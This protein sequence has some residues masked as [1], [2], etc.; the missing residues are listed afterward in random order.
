[1]GC[2]AFRSKCIDCKSMVNENVDRLVNLIKT[3][4]E[5][6]LARWREQVRQLPGAAGL[7]TPTINDEVPQLLDNL[8]EVLGTGSGTRESNAISAEHGLLRWQAGFD[9]TEVVAEYN[10][11]RQCLQDAAERD[12]IVLAGKTLQVMNE[13]FDDA[14]GKAVKAFETMMTIQLQHRHDEHLAFLLHDLRTPLEALSLATTLLE[15]SLPVDNRDSGIDSALSVLRGNINRLSKRVRLVISTASIIGRSF[16]PE[17]TL[18]NLQAQVEKVTRDLQPL[19]VSTGTALRNQVDD[20][21]EVYSDEILLG[22][23]FENLLSNALKFTSH[24]VIEIGARETSDGHSIQ[25]W[26]KDSGQGIPSEQIERIFERFETGS[27]PEQSGLGLGLAIVKEIIELHR[28]EI[29]VQS[30]LG[31]GSTF[32]FLLPR[33]EF[34]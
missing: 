22:Q 14:I 3:Q 21:I 5:A 33:T 2:A 6:L 34:S 23:I 12:G 15:R 31:K 7:D 1:M 30:E 24:G 28:G 19:A 25:C 10:I 8:A 17:F 20:Q 27:E 4:R 9:V 11:L 26:V 29:S 16:H 18:L 32:T 13:I